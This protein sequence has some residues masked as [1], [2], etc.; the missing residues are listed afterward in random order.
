MSNPSKLFARLARRKSQTSLGRGVHSRRGARSTRLWSI[1]AACAAIGSVLIAGLLG[2]CGPKPSAA[3]IELRKELQDSTLKLDDAGRQH[4]ADVATIRSLQ[5]NATTVPVLPQERVAELFTTH[6]IRIERLSGG[7]D[8]DPKSTGDEGLR[9]YV[10]PFDATNDDLKSAGTFTVEAFNLA[11]DAKVIG[12]WTFDNKQA[13][14]AWKGFGLLYEYV[15]ECPW[16]Q[17]QPTDPQLT[18]RV[19]FTDALTRRVFIEQKTIDV[20]VPRPGAT[21]AQ[22]K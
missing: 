5:Q 16:Q 17:V 7:M 19:T 1:T 22:A 15:L 6:G 11:A 13:R 8:S 9:I 10:T 12:K 18:V 20:Q 4:A 3:N 2:G 14:T 21:T